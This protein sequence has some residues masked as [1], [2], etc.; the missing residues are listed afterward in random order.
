MRPRIKKLISG[1][2]RVRKRLVRTGWD[3]IGPVAERIGPIVQI[4]GITVQVDPRL[5]KEVRMALLKGYFGHPEVQVV[6]SQL[7]QWD[8]VMELGAGIGVMSSLCAKRVGSERVFTYEG[9][10]SMERH[11]RR[12]YR[13]NRVSPTL[14]MC[15]IGEHAGLQSLYIAEDFWA[16]STIGGRPNARVI[17]VPV[18][19]FNLE[20][21]RLNPTF[22]IVDIEGAE[23]DLCRYAN[24]HHVQ[25]ISIE[26]HE[27]IIGHANLKFVRS[28]LQNAGFRLNEQASFPTV[29]F[30]QRD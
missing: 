17:R 10:P 18:R 9:N 8:T 27:H 20:L 12:T 11:I 3:L 29:L 7:S 5:G 22:L 6:K 1:A 24:F 26:V 4:E 14:E 23:Y 28:Q 16:S 19:P 30:F 25:K 15:L 13:L 21:Q 2:N